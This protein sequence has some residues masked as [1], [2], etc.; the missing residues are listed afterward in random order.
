MPPSE[1]FLPLGGAVLLRRASP[2]HADQF[3]ALARVAT[4]NETGLR[5]LLVGHTRY[6]L[7]TVVDGT[8]LPIPPDDPRRLWNAI[9]EAQEERRLVARRDAANRAL[10]VA[11]G[12]LAQHYGVTALGT[13]MSLYRLQAIAEREAI[14]AAA[15]DAVQALVAAE[16]TL[17]TI[18]QRP[19]PNSDRVEPALRS[20]CADLE[21][22][23]AV[24]QERDP[25]QFGEQRYRALVQAQPGTD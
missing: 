7:R 6:Y 16:R 4:L 8:Q 17:K 19:P 14:S 2:I 22:V 15:C 13:A 10:E 20:V 21:R 5:A 23:G 11:I 1:W 9:D 18:Y 25:T 12:A 3:E 24:L